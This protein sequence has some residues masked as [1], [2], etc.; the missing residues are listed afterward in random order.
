MQRV[1]TDFG[2][3]RLSVWT[4]EGIE[5]GTT[6]WQLAIEKAMVN[7]GCV[8]CIL[9]PDA[10][11][12]N[13]V[14][15]ELNYARL[16]SK[17]IFLMLARGDERTSVP[18]GWSLSQWVDI[19]TRKAYKDS[20][21]KLI[22]VLYERLNDIQLSP[23][24]AL[25]ETPGEVM[26]APTGPLLEDPP[27]MSEY[28][29]K[30]FDWCEIPAGDVDVDGTLNEVD[31]FYMAKYP[32]TNQQFQIFLDD[33]VGYRD[34]NWFNF[35]DEAKKWHRG[36]R[37]STQPIYSDFDLPRTYVNWY[38]AVAYTRWLEEKSGTSY[39]LTLPTEVQWQRAAQGDDGRL[40]P[41]GNHFDKQYCNTLTSKIGKPMPVMAY[42]N[43][44]SP[45]GV[46]DLCGNVSEWTLTVYDGSQNSER[47]L[48]RIIRGGAYD[49][50]RMFLQVMNR[51][52]QTPQS[53]NATIGFRICANFPD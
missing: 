28:F 36:I 31:R 41:W 26:L 23:T 49:S 52:S 3:S 33:P 12:S 34:P 8:V 27:T 20:M 4:D 38:E 14:R 25:P 45:Y 39:T 53:Q 17:D 7:S 29:A 51:S 30:P 46:F 16:Q 32:V 24:K 13:W 35:S 22:G 19:R 2:R 44:A 1:R 48:S 47:D 37:S 9:S 42:P 10:A 6:S 5:P 15:E 21:R 40:Y 11:Q 43:G 18:F 50:G